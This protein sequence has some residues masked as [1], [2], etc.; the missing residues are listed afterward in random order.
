MLKGASTSAAT[1]EYATALNVASKPA[2]LGF[3]NRSTAR[4]YKP[5]EIASDIGA[6]MSTIIG[7][8]IKEKRKEEMI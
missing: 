4:W 1:E 8:P 5:A 6:A 2:L 3:T 7:V